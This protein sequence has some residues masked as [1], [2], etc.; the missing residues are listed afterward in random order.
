MQQSVMIHLHN[1][2]YFNAEQSFWK[3]PL[4]QHD[5]LMQMMNIQK[6]SIN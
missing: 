4:F 2:M 3:I 1:I 5:K 6:P